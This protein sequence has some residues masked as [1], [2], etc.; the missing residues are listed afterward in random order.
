MDKRVYIYGVI[1]A[2][3]NTRFGHSSLAEGEEHKPSRKI[4]QTREVYT[5]PCRDIACVVRKTDTDSFNSLPKEVLGRRLVEH[6][7]VIEKVMKDYTVIPFKFGTIAEGPDEVNSI[8]QRAYTA[9]RARLQEMDKQIEL[10]LVASWNDI[11]PVIRRIGEEN[12]RIRTFR[13]EI[14]TK[15]PQETLQDRI[16]I[17]SMIK[18]A[19]D[20]E[21]RRL[22]EEMLQA[23]QGT[24]ADCQEH[25]LM[26]D[27]MVA[28]WAFLL[29]KDREADF[30]K[31]LDDFSERYGETIHFRC[32][33]PLPPY[34]FST[35]EVRKVDYEQIDTARRLLG[36]SEAATI[37]G[38][39][40]SYREMA[41]KFHPDSNPHD[42]DREKR[43]QNI[44]KAYELLSN[45]YR[46]V[47]GGAGCVLRAAEGRNFI[48][49]DFVKV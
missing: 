10:D 46:H 44:A 6:Q 35:I 11:N 20:E 45:C 39:K 31:A 34:S 43:F 25:E 19:L 47:D 14:A 29:A 36:L 40:E 12:K 15:P 1:A 4:G 37:D 17:G 33:G 16:K 26:N 2:N 9:I 28:N 13:N 38:V 18:D 24:V 23:L 42:P 8:L 32:V 30:D 49:V 22:R 3:E 7:T 41:R 27:K 21:K 5:I 48:L